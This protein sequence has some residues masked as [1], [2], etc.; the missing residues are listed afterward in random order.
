MTVSSA[1]ITHSW[2]PGAAMLAEPLAG[3]FAM[4]ASDLVVTDPTGVVQV[5]GTDYEVTGEPPTGPAPRRPPREPLGQRISLCLEGR[6]TGSL[7]ERAASTSGSKILHKRSVLTLDGGRQRSGQLLRGT[8]LLT[9]DL[10]NF[11]NPQ[12]P[13]P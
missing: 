8:C 3:L 12:T 13:L 1:T 9:S 4:Q 7:P 10:A 6:V 2:I 11:G 5:L